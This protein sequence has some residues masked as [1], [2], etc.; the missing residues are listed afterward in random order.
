MTASRSKDNPPRKLPTDPLP[1]ARDRHGSPDPASET[2]P[3]GLS[4]PLITSQDLF[5][6]LIDAPLEPD[7]AVSPAGVRKEP[8]RVQ[9]GEPSAKSSRAATGG[10]KEMNEVAADEMAALL[11]VFDT[12]ARE[13]PAKPA[14]KSAPPVAPAAATKAE[15]PGTAA[16][17]APPLPTAVKPPPPKP[18]AAKPPIPVAAAPKAP[19]KPAAPPAPRFAALDDDLDMSLEPEP[20]A[21]VPAPASRTATKFAAVPAR[22]KAAEGSGL[23]LAAVAQDAI[24]TAT[25]V[26]TGAAAPPGL[27]AERARRAAETVYGPYR[28]L[29]RIAVGGMAEV[30]RGKRSGVEGFEKVVAVKRILPHLS[31]NKEF[32]NMFIDEA[33]MVA[34]LTHPNIVQM[35]D[36]GKIDKTYFIAMEYVHGRDLRSIMKRGKERGIRIPLDLGVLVVGK[37]CAALEYA[38]RKKDDRG[39]ALKIV[40][41]DVSPQNI[42]ISYEGDVKLT[43]FG[44]AKAAARAPTTDR[45]ALRGKLLYMSP[46]QANGKSMDC[47][48]DVFSLGIV[49]YEMITDQRPFMS[50][51]EKSILE[52][53][54][55][56]QITAPVVINPRVPPRLEKIVMKALSRDPEDRYQDAADMGR[57]LERFLH[58]RNAPSPTA[59]ELARFM[60]VLFDETERGT[61][62]TDE[63]ST[64]SGEHRSGGND[65]EM[66]FESEPD[67]SGSAASGPL[68]PMSVQKLLKRFGLK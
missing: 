15:G 61:I 63:S 41:R 22:P 28:L 13:A 55:E 29:E 37:V 30:F 46:E 56:C 34:G 66:E 40:H 16:F 48:S 8:I 47:R 59:I 14:P 6:D 23:D 58:E 31:D 39:R 17:K 43:D 36:L 5:G 64:G 42:L 51:S 3:P 2:V 49:F 38:H 60:E 62:V 12:P 65:L 33:K 68:E 1:A 50:T 7:H 9:I 67:A 27:A 35:F 18:P 21:Q 25:P 57:D 45:G 44:I 19:Q 24:D 26:D 11:G 32:V 54:R 52:M 4:A 53:V 10:P 20:E